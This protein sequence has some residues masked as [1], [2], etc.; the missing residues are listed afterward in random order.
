MSGISAEVKD[1][2]KGAPKKT[3]KAI[4]LTLLLPAYFLAV[5]V[6]G[7]AGNPVMW[8]YL[9]ISVGFVFNCQWLYG[10]LADRR[11]IK[12][13]EHTAPEAIPLGPIGRILP[14]WMVDDLMRWI[15]VAFSPY[16]PYARMDYHLR[17]N[18]HGYQ[19]L[20]REILA[21]IVAEQWEQR[22]RGKLSKD[23]NELASFEGIKEDHRASVLAHWEGMSH[24]EIILEMVSDEILYEPSYKEEERNL[25]FLRWFP[26]SINEVVKDGILA[27]HA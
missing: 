13:L 15:P 24:Y 11:I 8:L 20:K 23:V 6:T 27:D 3:S 4:L 10:Y 16:S 26:R 19:F 2:K 5:I 9:L 17:K 14:A 18:A 22:E 7:Q 21:D 25:Y 12:T 1:P